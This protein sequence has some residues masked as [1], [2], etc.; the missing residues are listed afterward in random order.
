MATKNLGMRVASA[1][2]LAPLALAAAYLG[3]WPFA[4]FWGFAAIVVLWE[5]ITLV[6]GPV[7][8]LVFSSGAAALGVAA[9]VAWLERP[10]A[11]LL[12]VG[13]GM[14]S[15]ATFAPRERRRWVA[16][17]VAYAGGMLLAPI[18]LRADKVY[19]FM[20]IVLLFAIVW[21][22]DIL[23]YFAGR[24]F[25][26]PKLLPAI[27][28][29]KTWSGAIAGTVCGVIAAVLVARLSGTLSVWIVAIAFALCVLAQVGDL[30]E[31]WIKRK[32]QAKDSGHLIPGHGGA[33]D[34]LDGFWAAAVAAC[35][36]GLLRGGFEAPAKGLLIW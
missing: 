11:A 21:T 27:S 19:G 18:L 9:L 32:F 20:A 2:V 29:K 17:G 3:D 12:M 28:P 33:M 31:S 26:G 22:T 30:L 7:Y 13:L 10:I 8:R 16:S 34:R 5:W 36:I 15:S 24:A 4:L 1:L 14:L 25:G 6:L 23:A 35:V